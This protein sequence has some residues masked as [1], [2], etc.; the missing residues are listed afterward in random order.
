MEVARH[1][2][3]MRLSS[4]PGVLAP[5]R[6]APLRPPPLLSLVLLPV[7]GD[8]LAYLEGANLA[9]QRV[10]A[11]RTDVGRRAR[12]SGVWRRTHKPTG[13]CALRDICCSR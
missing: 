11:G 5:L 4:E 12:T 7:H 13:I 1:L 9:F 8:T 6:L 10:A 3:S 2:L